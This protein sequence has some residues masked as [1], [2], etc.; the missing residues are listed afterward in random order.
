MLTVVLLVAGMAGEPS[1]ATDPSPEA[2][3]LDPPVQVHATRIEVQ[4]PL[5]IR[6]NV[7]PIRYPE[8]NMFRAAIRCFASVSK[9]VSVRWHRPAEMR[10]RVEWEM[11]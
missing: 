2:H 5:T 11:R 10:C 8:L 3:V 1:R 7:A 9:A 4:R 6:S